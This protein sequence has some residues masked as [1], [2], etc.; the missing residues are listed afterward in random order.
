LVRFLHQRGWPEV[1]ERQFI[2][3]TLAYRGRSHPPTEQTGDQ[4]PP[5]RPAIQIDAIVWLTIILFVLFLMLT[6]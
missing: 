3:N 2:T 4:A 5:E 6:L 1:T